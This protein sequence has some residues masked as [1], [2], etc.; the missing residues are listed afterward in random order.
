MDGPVTLLRQV[1]KKVK[2]VTYGS[3]IYRLMLD[4]GEVPDSLQFDI[5][6]PWPGDSKVGQALIASQPSLFDGMEE[7]PSSYKRRFLTH[8]V[9]RDLRAVGTDMARRKA[10]ALILD[11]VEAQE[12]WD[13][14]GWAAP[15]LGA[16]LANWIAFYEFYAPQL[17]TD[18][19]ADLFISMARQLRHLI[20]IAPANLTGTENLLVI[21]GL[22]Y[23]GLAVAEREEALGLGLELLYRQLETEIYSDGGTVFRQPQRHAEMLRLF[24]DIRE[25]LKDAKIDV[26]MDLTLAIS[27]MVPALKFFRHGDGKLAL[28]HGGNEDNAL[29]LDA[30]ITFSRA[31]GHVVKHL[32]K[33]GFERMTAGRSLFLLDVGAP[34][35]KPFDRDAHAGLLGFEF[36]VGRER[37]IVNCGA[38]PEGDEAWHTAMAATAAHSTIT[39]GNMN[40]CELLPHGGI[41]GH[42]PDIE[43]Q[44]FEQDG[45]QV[46]EASHDAY[47]ARHKVTFHRMFGLSEDGHTL[48]GREIISGSV[49]KEFTVR[50][51][52]PPEVNVLLV[53]GGGAAL[54]RLASGAGWRL[55]VY[56]SFAND[57]ALES[58]IYCGDGT[59]RRTLQL[60]VSGMIRENP[61]YVDWT[62]KKEPVKKGKK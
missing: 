49:G 10:A 50:W 25:V 17:P 57:L 51:H 2:S 27:R 3:P 55:K 34:P 41:G 29:L 19:E 4:Q 43:C 14:D 36:S 26:P 37:L 48:R 45:M 8:D 22:I 6:D 46:I 11:W 33:T 7:L 1:R 53:Q 32:P 47:E 15:V 56:E 18:F 5:K 60:R 62:L 52:F 38:G 20:K 21:K 31:R 28:F 24:I 44:R 35:S 9:L 12:V 61:T 23:G 42:R 13:E 54:I 39:L 59:P 16:R 40:A 30:A 58:S